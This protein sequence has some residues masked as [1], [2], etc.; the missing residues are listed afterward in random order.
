M[1]R[2]LASAVSR[3][4]WTAQEK[5]NVVR[6]YLRDG[7]SL[8]V[9]EGETGATPGQISQWRTQ[10]LESLESVFDRSAKQGEE[11]LRNALAGRDARI[12]E[13]EGVIRE[14][15]AEV[16]GLKKNGGVR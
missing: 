11:Q 14:L 15:S 2:Q 16:L 13:L 4:R 6:R 7:V 5:A 9:L 1:T 3:R 12:S 10:V 8:T